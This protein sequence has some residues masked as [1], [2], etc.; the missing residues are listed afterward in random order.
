MVKRVVL[1]HDKQDLD[2]FVRRYVP[3]EVTQ[4]VGTA[5]VLYDPRAVSA[6]LDDGKV[7]RN[8]LLEAFLIHLRSLD[9]FLGKTEDGRNPR[10]VLAI[11]LLDTWVPRNFLD[12]DV[13]DSVNAQLAHLSIKR[14]PGPEHPWHVIKLA[15]DA[16]EALDVFVNEL[17]NAGDVQL[18]EWAAAMES[19]TEWARNRIEEMPNTELMFS[20]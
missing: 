7:I 15:V 3:Y 4:L 17:R 8:A 18:A 13:R 16:I 5:A 11:D 19:S 12:E 6:P 20:S 10:D 14:V 1:P 9:D 2:L